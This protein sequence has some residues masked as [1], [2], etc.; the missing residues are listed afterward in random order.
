M[1][2]GPG[3]SKFSARNQAELAEAL[4]IDAEISER[5]DAALLDAFFPGQGARR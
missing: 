2:A 3:T 5:L 4:R 1:K